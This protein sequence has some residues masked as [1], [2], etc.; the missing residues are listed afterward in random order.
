MSAVDGDRDGGGDTLVLL[1]L[2]QRPE[3]EEVPVD[4]V[5]MPSPS[6]DDQ[7]RAIGVLREHDLGVALQLGNSR[8]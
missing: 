8:G 4:Q 3:A 6:S 7:R 1:G 2:P 5:R